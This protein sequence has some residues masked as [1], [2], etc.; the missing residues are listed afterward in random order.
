MR[1]HQLELKLFG[2]EARSWLGSLYKS[3]LHKYPY[4]CMHFDII[5]IIFLKQLWF[6]A[7]CRPIFFIFLRWHQLELKLFG[8]GT[9]YWPSILCTVS[10]HSYVLDW[11]NFNI[12]SNSISQTALTYRNFST[13]F[14]IFVRWHHLISS[15]LGLRP[16][17]DLVN[18]TQLAWCL[19]TCYL[20]PKISDLSRS[21]SNGV[22]LRRSPAF[23]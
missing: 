17:L 14:F 22:D 15:C 5:S 23:L 6:I 12:I 8:P 1:W 9:R 11:V 7:S 16:A 18:W 10:L 21:S 20:G 4:D 2:P 19:D 3:S 13:H